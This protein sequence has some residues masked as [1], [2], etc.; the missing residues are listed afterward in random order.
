MFPTDISLHSCKQ[1]DKLFYMEK[2]RA[3]LYKFVV[4]SAFAFEVWAG[5]WAQWIS[6]F[7]LKFWLV[8]LF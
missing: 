1:S 6:S 8:N 2:I 3:K 4:G 7:E 5:F